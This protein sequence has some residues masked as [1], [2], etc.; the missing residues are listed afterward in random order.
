MCV[1]HAQLFLCDSVSLGMNQSFICVYLI[2]VTINGT[3]HNKWNMYFSVVNQ[4]Y[5]K[6]VFSQ[7]GVPIYKPSYY[8]TITMSQLKGIFYSHNNT[9]IPQLS[10]RLHNLHEAADI[11]DKVSMT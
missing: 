9:E 7:N 11:L 4:V 10:L 6:F 1:P 8:S 5:I 2:G 3:R